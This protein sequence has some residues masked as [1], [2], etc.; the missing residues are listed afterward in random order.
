MKRRAIALLACAFALCLALASCGGSGAKNDAESFIGTWK[1]TSIEGENT[2]ISESEMELMESMGMSITLTLSEDRSAAF[3]FLGEALTGTWEAKGGSTAV[4]N[5]G[6]DSINLTLA[7]GKLTMSYENDSMVFIKD[8]SAKPSANT[9]GSGE[10]NAANN[11]GKNE[12]SP[13]T[14][15][16][17]DAEAL[18]VTIADDNV[19][20]IIVLGKDIDWADDPGYTL[21]IS[22]NSDTTIYVTSE[23]G[24]F[25]VNG[26]MLDPSL[27]ETV[28]PG[29]YVEA[30]MYFDGD[31]LDGGIEALVNVEGTIKAMND[32]SWD[33]LATYSFDL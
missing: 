26:K 9:N 33:T 14:D 13:T 17:T 23:Y 31:K 10:P 24:T 5:S 4:F 8:D 1:L 20:T 30:F 16:A 6:G 29:K 15:P 11:S 21:K 27:G 3:D 2:P 28:Q 19:C 12:T 32:D 18:D 22:N 25:S 7:D